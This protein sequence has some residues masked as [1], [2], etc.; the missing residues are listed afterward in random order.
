MY[1]FHM[2]YIK[3][4]IHNILAEEFVMAKFIVFFHSYCVWI[5]CLLP[6]SLTWC[7]C[8]HIPGRLYV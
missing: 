4:S 2:I 8:C 6:S 5:L 3:K 7:L 1:Y